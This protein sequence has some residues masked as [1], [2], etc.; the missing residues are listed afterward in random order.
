MPNGF[1]CNVAGL[2]FRVEGGAGIA[3]P[4]NYAPFACADGGDGDPEGGDLFR[5]VV[6]DSAPRRSDAT[7]IG[8][9]DD[10][11]AHI[12]VWTSDRGGYS[13][14]IATPDGGSGA[15][16]WLEVDAAFA[17]ARCVLP[18]D[19]RRRA[20]GLDNCLM[21]CYAFAAASRGALLVH[22]SAVV[23]EGRA[24]LFLGKS[25]TGKSTHS[26]LWLAE[27]AGSRLLN[28]DNPV[29]RLLPDGSVRAY[30]SPWSGKTPCYVN[31]DAPVGACVRLRQAPCNAVAANRP[32]QA[33]AH[34]LASCST[35]MWDKRVH[36]G[37]CDTLGK[38][39]ATVPS[40]TLDCLP[41][42]AA[43]ALCHAAA[44]ADGASAHHGRH[45]RQ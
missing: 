14:Q 26:R 42:R 30:G 3:P 7:L 5:L 27:V 17:D 29:V 11:A 4:A 23:A 25:G 21:L 33:F 32:A 45:G 18:S 24:W 1:S 41:D 22:A 13:F 20:F 6:A 36:G 40:F 31:E 38:I 34:L 35:M 2:R 8:R 28:D 15:G 10:D 9:F 44:T 12:A 16:T 39:A 37:V 43:A 19:P